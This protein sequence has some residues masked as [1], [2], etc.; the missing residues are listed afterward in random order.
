MLGDLQIGSRS[1]P[2]Y[3]V[4]VQLLLG[5]QGFSDHHRTILAAINTLT[6]QAQMGTLP[7]IPLPTLI[8]S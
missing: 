4:A 3:L 1:L 5:N 7:R 8:K 2:Q 6:P